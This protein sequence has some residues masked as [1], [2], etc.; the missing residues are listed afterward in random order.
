MHDG[1]SDSESW[2]RCGPVILAVGHSARDT[3]GMLVERGVQVVTKPFQIG[4]RIEH[5]QEMV[6]RWQ[7]GDSAGHRKLGPAEYH[8]VAKGVCTSEGG[9]SATDLFSFCMCPGG[10]ILPTNESPGLVATNGASRASR[11]GRFANSGLVITMDPARMGPARTGLDAMGA[12]AYVEQWERKAFKATGGTYRIPAQRAEHYLAGR[13]SDGTLE[14]SYPLG[15]HWTSIRDLIPK[16]AAEALARG[17]VLLDKK[18]PGFAGPDAIVTA[19]ETRASAPFRILRDPRT[20]EAP[21][22]AGLFPVGEGAGYAGGIVSA[23]V[24]GIKAADLIIERYAPP[25]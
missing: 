12:I 13:A 15:G 3:V 18:F 2:M 23:A 10:V 1:G 9:D 22:A 24:D 21:A 8:M 7:Y 6:N 4:V 11:S 14:T 5:P 17:L 19:P 20:F 16:P 25:R